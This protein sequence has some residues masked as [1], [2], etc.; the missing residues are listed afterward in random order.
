MINIPAN[1]WSVNRHTAVYR[2]IDRL[3]HCVRRLDCLCK[4]FNTKSLYLH[5]FRCYS[6]GQF[7]THKV[8]KMRGCVPKASYDVNSA[9]P[10]IGS[11]SKPIM[12]PSL[13]QSWG[14][15]NH[16]VA[17]VRVGRS[18]RIQNACFAWDA[19]FWLRPAMRPFTYPESSFAQFP[20]IFFHLSAGSLAWLFIFILT[21]QMGI[22]NKI[23]LVLE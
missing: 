4:H 14:G 8:C 17:G 6:S 10:Q 16:D 13:S 9:P 22:S 11:L 21:L 19:I 12:V 18:R 3:S 23:G 5:L 1:T 20:S 15:G 2:P 7:W